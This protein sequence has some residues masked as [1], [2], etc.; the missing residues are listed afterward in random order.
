MKIEITEMNWAGSK[1][2]EERVSKRIEDFIYSRITSEIEGNELAEARVMASRAI[3]ALGRL[4]DILAS[5]GLLTAD[6]IV[7]ISGGDDWQKRLQPEL[8]A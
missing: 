5:K 6:E 2:K 1:P 4:A 8:T 7:A 3:S